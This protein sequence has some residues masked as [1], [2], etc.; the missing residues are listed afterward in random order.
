M[1]RPTGEEVREIT[2]EFPVYCCNGASE[3]L[4]ISDDY[5]WSSGQP[6]QR[7]GQSMSVI[8][9]LPLCAFNSA[10]IDRLVI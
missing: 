1:Y 4:H 9:R 10:V 7:D 2:L 3:L 8:R 6:C 5:F